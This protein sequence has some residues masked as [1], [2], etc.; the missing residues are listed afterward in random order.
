MEAYIQ[1]GSANRLEKTP[2][3]LDTHRS[4]THSGY[5]GGGGRMSRGVSIHSVEDIE[6][7]SKHYAAPRHAPRVQ[8]H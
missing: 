4:N 1:D 7:R 2:E 6:A 3:R 5:V 8:H